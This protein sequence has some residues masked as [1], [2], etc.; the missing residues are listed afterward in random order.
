[1][2]EIVFWKI[3]AQSKEERTNFTNQIEIL[4]NQ[5]SL[6]EERD[7]I[8]FEYILREVLAKSYHFNI[9]AAAKIVYGY[10]SDDDFLYFR[11]RLIAEGKELFLKS[12]KNPEIIPKID[13]IELEGEDMLYI[14]DNAFIKKFGSETEKELPRDIAID[15]LNYD[16]GYEIKGEN[17]KEHELK[18]KYPKLW[19]KYRNHK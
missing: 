18:I 6:L 10:V 7:I 19:K 17:W 11:C 5:I 12:I 16:D 9:L 2:T 1:M 3:I 13:L 8:E 15:Y 4:T 14:T